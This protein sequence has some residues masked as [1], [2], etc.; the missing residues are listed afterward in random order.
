MDDNN[1]I[2]NE[3]I[4]A[5]DTILPIHAKI[6]INTRSINHAADVITPKIT[7]ISKGAVEKAI[8]PSMEY[9]RSFQNDHLVS[10]ATRSIFLYS[11]HLILNPTHPNMPF[12]RC[13]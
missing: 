3:R 1:K 8:M 7:G 6:I 13:V 4:K 10:P 9:K 5:V 12:E 2:K 11:S